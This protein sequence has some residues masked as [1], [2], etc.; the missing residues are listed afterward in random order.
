MIYNPFNAW[1][2]QREVPAA[3]PSTFRQW[4]VKNR[5]RRAMSSRDDILERVRRNQ[6]AWRALPAMPTFDRAAA[7]IRWSPSARRWRGWAA[8]VAVPPERRC[9]RRVHS[10]RAFREARVICSATPEVRRHAG[11]RRRCADPAELD[12]VDVGVVRAVFGV[13]ETGSVWLSEREFGVNAL[14]FLSQHLVVLLDPRAIVADLHRRLPAPRLPRGALRRV[15]DR[16]VGDRRH[17][18]RAD[19]RRA[20]HPHAHR[21]SRC[22]APTPA[23]PPKQGE[24]HD[25]AADLQ[26]VREHGGV[27]GAGGAAG[28]RH[29]RRPRLPAPEGARRR[30]ARPA[31]GA[32]G[33]D[34]RLRHAG[35]DGG[36]GGDARRLHRAAADRL[37][38]PQH[39]LPA[40]ARR[41]ERRVQDPGRLDRQHHAGPAPAAAADR[42]LVRRLLR[43]RG[44]LRHAGGGDRRD[45][46]RP[47]LLAA[48]GVGPLADRQHRAG[49][50]RRARHADHHAWPRCTATT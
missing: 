11:H 50:L 6:P 2:R 21:H 49:R 3:P 46:H 24:P 10:A 26:P 9:A 40:P 41:Q 12:D 43:R 37:D 38:R 22:R 4:Y 23:A 34:P 29:A 25:L 20:G 30:R 32:G 1:G 36:Q 16:P 28:G 18:R 8:R 33:R 13:A 17:R 14:G 19:P 35:R 15:H 42:V 48:R 27:D 31:R 5:G 44:R 47:R 39:H 45:P 7:P